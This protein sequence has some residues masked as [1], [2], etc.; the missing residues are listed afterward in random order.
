MA[1]Y[2]LNVYLREKLKREAKQMAFIK[3]EKS[4]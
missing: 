3:A 1:G 2:A 4:K